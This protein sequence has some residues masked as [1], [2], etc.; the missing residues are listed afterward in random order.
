VRGH[1]GCW[2]HSWE[3]AYLRE[4]LEVLLGI[5]KSGDVENALAIRS[6]VLF[7]TVQVVM[8]VRLHRQARLLLIWYH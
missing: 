5:N 6:R 7:C 2:R 1:E 4:T 3:R 8:P